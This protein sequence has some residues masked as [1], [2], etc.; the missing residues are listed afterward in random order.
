[1]AAK[2]AQK[3]I[4]LSDIQFAKKDCDLND[5]HSDNLGVTFSE[6]SMDDYEEVKDF[7][8]NE[9]APDEPTARS[10]GIFDGEGFFD[11]KVRNMMLKEFIQPALKE[12]HSLVARQK[13]SNKLL[14]NFFKFLIINSI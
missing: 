6:C 5:E 1:M 13:G 10:A 14:G 3:V 12:P 11:K 2:E 9:F 7:F 8:K 4:E